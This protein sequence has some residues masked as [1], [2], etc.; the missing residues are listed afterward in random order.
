MAKNKQIDATL[1]F[2]DKFTGAMGKAIDKLKAHTK[3]FKAAGAQIEKV[4]KQWTKAGKTLT[5]GVTAPIAG[6]A[7]ASVKT[8]ADFESGMSKVQSILGI[9]GDKAEIEMSKL[10]EKAKEMGAKTKFSASESA[11]AFSYMAMAGWETED[12]LNGIEGIMYLAG[13]TGEDLASTSDIVTDA[14][15]AF[16]MKADETNRFVDVLAKTAST[17]NTNVSMMGETFKYLAPVAGALGYNVEDTAT[18]IGLMANSGIK[19]SNAGTALRSLLTNLSKPGKAAANAMEDLG[20]SLTDSNGEMKPLNQLM[21][22]MRKSFSGLTESQKS[23]Y[24]ASL[25]GKTGMAGL[26]AIVNASDD[27]FKSLAGSISDADGAAEEMYKTANDNL[28]GQLTVM[29]STMESI[30]IAIGEKLLPYIKKIVEKMQG[31]A[32]KINNLDDGQMDMIIK[33]AGIVAAIGPLLL[34]IGKVI[35]TVGKVKKFLG[36]FSKTS[37]I[38][39]VKILLIVAAIAAIAAIVYVVY[40]NWGKISDWFKNLWKRIGNYVEVTRV[41]FGAFVKTIQD[42]FNNARDSVAEFVQGVRDKFN[43]FVQSI[44]DKFNNARDS[45]AEFVQSVRDKFN[46]FV[47]S[48]KDKFNNARDSVAEFVQSVRDKFNE[49]VQSIKDRYNSVKEHIA[50]FVY[51]IREKFNEFVGKFTE[52]G[53]V[54]GAVIQNIKN[55]ING[56]KTVFSGIIQFVKNVFTGNWKAAWEGV[57]TVFKSVFSSLGNVLKKPLN[58]VIGL[59]NS[60][61]GGINKISVTIPDWSPIGGGQTIG[62]NIPEIPYLAKGT[63]YFGGGAAVINEKGGEIVDLPRG[64]RVIPHDKSVQQAYKTGQQKGGRVVKIEKIADSIIVREEADIDKIAETIAKK[65]EE[66]EDNVA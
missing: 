64:T 61:I 10:T 20:I 19:A 37:A 60:A 41:V 56:I 39:N 33:I 23:Q 53:G 15:T 21:Q 3:T 6:I 2:N 51:S 49:F 43:E 54:I 46:E 8:A 22:D 63:A 50:E 58:G 9:T 12:M 34:V 26:L 52:S 30:S 29:K 7:V 16:G 57:K 59:I 47:Q 11:D 14:L 31:W 27:D 18:A 25:A 45:V 55:Y 65:L 32:E 48:I 24:A 28:N 42:K 62:F 44:K 36:A 66:T 1:K 5:A 38:M 40:K 4:G 35:T 17:S 13:A